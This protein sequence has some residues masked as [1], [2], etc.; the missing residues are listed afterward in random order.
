MIHDGEDGSET[1]VLSIA[2]QPRK[3]FDEAPVSK[4]AVS[5]S[6]KFSVDSGASPEMRQKLVP[7]NCVA[8]LHGVAR[9]IVAAASGTCPCGP[10]ILPAVNYVAIINKKLA[11]L[12]RETNARERLQAESHS[13]A[14]DDTRRD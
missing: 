13:E 7:F 3:D 8:I 14:G 6:G 11:R 10:I 4:V 5:L 1:V 12:R 9:G 2:I